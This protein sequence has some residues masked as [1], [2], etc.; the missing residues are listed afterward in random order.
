MDQFNDAESKTSRFQ[1]SSVHLRMDNFPF[2]VNFF[3]V[4]LYNF[5]FFCFI[6]SDFDPFAYFSLFSLPALFNF[7]N[8]FFFRKWVNLKEGRPVIN[9]GPVC[10]SEMVTGRPGKFS[11]QRH[12]QYKRGV[13][14]VNLV[15]AAPNRVVV[16]GFCF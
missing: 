8:F 5:L 14:H 7:P 15:I 9:V 12:F 13:R 1:L 2:F 16:G 4:Q 6:K 10:P 11:A 3:S